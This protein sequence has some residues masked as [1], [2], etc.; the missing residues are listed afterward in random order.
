MAGEAMELR[1]RE[2][3]GDDV[4]AAMLK[5]VGGLVADGKPLPDKFVL[6]GPAA[7]AYL[8]LAK[9]LSTFQVAGLMEQEP[10]E[11]KHGFFVQGRAV[12]V[13]FE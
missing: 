11:D 3:D 9:E 5:L 6:S 4:H 1:I 7:K 12:P 2:F 8:W 10:I 13:E